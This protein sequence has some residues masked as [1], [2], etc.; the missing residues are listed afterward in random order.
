MGKDKCAG[1][2]N[3]LGMEILW[4]LYRANLKWEPNQ[5]NEEILKIV[6]IWV[7]STLVLLLTSLSKNTR[8]K[9]FCLVKIQSYAITSDHVIQLLL[10]IYPTFILNYFS[11]TCCCTLL[12][13]FFD[14]QQ[15]SLKFTVQIY[16]HFK[17]YFLS[18]YSQ[19]VT[20][21]IAVYLAPKL[22]LWIF[23]YS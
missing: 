19:S 16:H 1:S 20:Y 2:L 3:M 7:T 15:S 13:Y 21:S 12:Y 18:S 22:L 17:S 23:F 8:L 5:Y 6:Q 11:S 4:S 14:I 10:Q 9:V